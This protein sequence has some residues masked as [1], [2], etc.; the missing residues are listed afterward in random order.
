[1]AYYVTEW[2]DI[3]YTLFHLIAPDSDTLNVIYL[4]GYGDVITYLYH[5]NYDLDLHDEVASGEFS[6]DGSYTT[7]IAN[8]TEL[9]AVP[10]SETLVEGVEI[11]GNTINY[12]GNGPGWILWN[13]QY[14]DLYPFEFVDC[15]YCT[16]STYDAGWYELHS[17]LSDNDGRLCFGILYLILSNTDR[18]VLGYPICLDPAESQENAYIDAQWSV[19]ESAASFKPPMQIQLKRHGLTL[20]PGPPLPSVL[21]HDRLSD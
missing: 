11:E 4:Y 7:S 17:I 5:E 2:S 12:Q 8:L 15:S 1:M 19:D 18:I 10:S 20:W 6:A 21:Q 14:Y 13:E 3:N 16:S 9:E